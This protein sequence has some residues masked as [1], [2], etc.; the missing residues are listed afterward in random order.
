MLQ[1]VAYG[2]IACKVGHSQV[3][4]VSLNTPPA[5]ARV[6][7]F[8]ARRCFGGV[9]QLGK[10]SRQEIDITMSLLDTPLPNRV[11]FQ[12][13]LQHPIKHRRL[14]VLGITAQ[15]GQCL[16]CID[17]RQSL[18]ANATSKIKNGPACITTIRKIVLTL[19]LLQSGWTMCLRRLGELLA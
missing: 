11:S 7:V 12:A 17:Q 14:S 19:T 5:K 16:F 1:G 4:H 6:G 9:S 15:D 13:D 18:V 8:L 2:S 3:D 10:R